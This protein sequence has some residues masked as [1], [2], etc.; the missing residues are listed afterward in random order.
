VTGGGWQHYA[1][2]GLRLAG[3]LLAALLAAAPAGAQAD[4]TLDILDGETLYEDGWLVTLGYGT[5]TRDQLQSGWHTVP[6][7]NNRRRVQRE[8]VLGV[9]YGLRNDLQLSLLLPRVQNS[10]TSTIGGA[11]TRISAEGQGDAIALVKWRFHRW[12]AP[13]EALNVALLVGAELPTGDDR[14]RDD[15]VLVPPELQPGSGSLDGLVGVAATYEP[16]RW[17][18]NAAALYKHAGEGHD[19]RAGDEWLFELAAG[20]RFWLEPYPGPFMRFD[21]LL[22][23]RHA[24]RSQQDGMLV[25]DSGGDLTTLGANLAFRPRPALDFQLAVETPIDE[26]VNGTQLASGTTVT[27]NFG[28]RF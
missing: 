23:Q 1:G 17:R 20:N 3:P 26:Q 22:R 8:T 14:E 25:H 15:G 19:Y 18:F 28:Y 2:D 13:H 4:A 5:E 24:D 7:P 16:R 11:T 21:L 10:E 6:D 9:N 27:L 12:D